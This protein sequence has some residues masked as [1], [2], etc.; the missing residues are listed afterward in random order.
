MTVKAP[1]KSVPCVVI[2]SRMCHDTDRLSYVNYEIPLS[3][4]CRS[5]PSST[6]VPFLVLT[7][8]KSLKVY[9]VL[10]TVTLSYERDRCYPRIND[11]HPGID[12]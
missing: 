4:E 8:Q 6:I 3:V 7:G 11:T 10:P 1:D 9:E 12:R 2:T 5:T